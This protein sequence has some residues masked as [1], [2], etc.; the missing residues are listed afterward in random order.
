MRVGIKEKTLPKNIR[1]HTCSTLICIF[2]APIHL[3]TLVEPF[4]EYLLSLFQFQNLTGVPLLSEAVPKFHT[5]HNKI[6]FKVYKFCL[7]N[8]KIISLLK[9][10]NYSNKFITFKVEILSEREF[11]LKFKQSDFNSSFWFSQ[12]GEIPILTTWFSKNNDEAFEGVI[13]ILLLMYALLT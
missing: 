5:Y 9:K 12:L 13:I 6:T 4:L 8:R 10:L 7:K 2:Q 1:L 11:L 3:P